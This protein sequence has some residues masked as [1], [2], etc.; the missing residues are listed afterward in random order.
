VYAIVGYQGFQYRVAKDEVLRVPVF[1]SAEGAE[2]TIE[3][4]RLIAD[5]EDVLVGRPTIPDAVV[6]AEV[7]GQGRGPKLRVAKFKRRKDYRRV[8]GHRTNFTEIRVKEIV[9]P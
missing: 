1:E 4:V 2:I 7:V 6:K 8:R 3:D 9:R 5:G